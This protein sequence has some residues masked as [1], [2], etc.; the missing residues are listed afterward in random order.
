MAMTFTSFVL[1]AAQD[2]GPVGNGISWAA[3]IPEAIDYA[4]Q[5]LYRELNL[6][7]TIARDSTGLT[8]ANT[9]NFTLPSTVGRFVVVQ[10][11][12]ILTPAGSDINTGTMNPVVP[13]S[14]D[15]LQYYWPSD[16]AASATTIPEI[17]AM[18]TDQ[19]LM[20][21]PPP[22][23]IFTV[24]VVGPIR[25]TTLSAT[26]PTTYLTNYLPDLFHAAAMVSLTKGGAEWEQTYQ[27]LF[28]SALTEEG[29]KRA[30]GASWTPYAVEPGA[31]PQRG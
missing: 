24:E 1:R 4:E 31:I 22:G 11:I 7:G 21:G 10:N 19:T 18:V 8:T 26:N 13:A 12:N 27:M 2:I 5:R 17:Y 14:L 15:T 16:T 29:R 23:A 30:A 9:R 3:A 28:K 6:L 25:P 20:F